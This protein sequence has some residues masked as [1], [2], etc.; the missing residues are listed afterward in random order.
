MKI[1]EIKV[2]GEDVIFYFEG[3]DDP[4]SV[5]EFIPG[6]FSHT[7]FSKFEADILAFNKR[8]EAGND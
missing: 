5:Q 8:W 2:E 7:T 1:K 3:S 4:W 6:S